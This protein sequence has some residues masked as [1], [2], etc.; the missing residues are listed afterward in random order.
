MHAA[1]RFLQASS[2]RAYLVAAGAVMTLALL[3]SVPALVTPAT[4][5][6]TPGPVPYID[7]WGP[8]GAP[9]RV[10]LTPTD[11]PARSQAVTWRT[12]TDVLT[13]VAQIAPIEGGPGFKNYGNRSGRNE[14]VTV[15]G[16]TTGDVDETLHYP[17]RFHTAVFEGLEPDTTYLYRVGDGSGHNRTNWSEWYEFTTATDGPSDFS[18]IYYG[19]AQNDIKEHA[20]RVFRKAFAQRPDAELILHAG[21]LVDIGNRDY[22][23]G[24]WFHA[25]GFPI[26][27]I[28]Q[29]A[30]PGN[31]EYS[32][33]QGAPGLNAYWDTQFNFPDNGPKAPA[34]TEFPLVYEALNRGNVHYVD[35]Q[36]VRFIS[37]DSNGSAVPS[38]AQRQAWFDIQ[39]EWLDEVL[40]S[41]PNKWTVVYHHHPIFSVS[42][43]RNNAQVRDA[44]LPVIEANDVDLVLAGHDHN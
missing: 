37:L 36:G 14:V 24:E 17:M 43:G 18:F 10:V 20:S 29:I 21:D 42:S 19:D 2:R 32:I 40:K 35:Y 31:H 25:N 7:L 30:S 13:P 8:T 12:S 38:G 6:G 15:S 26:G 27:Q 23:W 28:N 39:A 11:D 16:T 44:W 3:L 9:D 1:L 33:Q 34:D 5:Q 4:G 22:E 41:N